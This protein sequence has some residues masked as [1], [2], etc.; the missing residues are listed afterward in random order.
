MRKISLAAGI[1]VACAVAGPAEAS[2]LVL[3]S[4]AGK[5]CYEAARNQ[6][7]SM[8]ALARCDLALDQAALTSEEKVATFVNR[9]VVKLY[10]GNYQDAIQDFDRA[11]ALDPSEPESYLNKAS[12]LLRSEASPAEAKALFSQALERDTRR[13]E[14]AFFGRAIANEL[15]GDIKSAYQDYKRAQEA[16]PRWQQPRRELSRFQ[17][18]RASTSL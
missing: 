16:A 5:E 18:K 14:L 10:R 8:D 17:V 7:S 6:I 1:L 3:G 12:A 2:V 9:G 15:T 13:P 11:I 4:D